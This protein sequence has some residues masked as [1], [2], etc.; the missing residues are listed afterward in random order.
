MVW[1]ANLRHSI[2][3]LPDAHRHGQKLALTIHSHE[4]ARAHGSRQVVQHI[5][6]LASQHSF[7]VK[8]AVQESQQP[9]QLLPWTSCRPLSE[10]PIAHT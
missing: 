1:A 4:H 8:A 3:G 9:G 2:D 5:G 10:T 6:M 7:H